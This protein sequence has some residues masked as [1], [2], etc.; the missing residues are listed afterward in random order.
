[1]R[2]SAPIY[3]LKREAKMLARSEGIA[4]H[5]ALDRIAER[6]GFSAWSLLA[7]R[8]ADAAPAKTLYPRLVPADMVL[9]GARPGHGK[10]LM[11]LELMVAAM[12]AGHRGVFFTLEYS[13]ADM[14]AAF[15]A[16]GEDPNT[17]GSRFE[18]DNSDAISA[19]YM[20]GRLDRAARGTLVVVDYLQLLDQKRTHPGVMEQI[21]SLK[22]FALRRGVIFIFVSQ[23]DRSYAATQ[24][25][26]PALEDVR[27]P[28]PLDL[29]LFSKSC[30]LHD[31]EVH[32]AAMN[33][34]LRGR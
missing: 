18:F 14:L 6:E 27:L 2:L 23:I 7:A 26:V 30:F 17:F 21:R 5:R 20:I 8:A 15:Q 34:S 4:L 12:R 32:V 13:A 22:T 31:G 28:N 1:M 29:S 11:S 16:I 9:L 19:H 10:T 33:E 24:R 3:R 25:T